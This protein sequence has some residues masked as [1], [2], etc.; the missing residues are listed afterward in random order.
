MNVPYITNALISNAVQAFIIM[1]L[2]VIFGLIELKI[3]DNI[4]NL[5]IAIL[6]L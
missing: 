3:E 4:V 5:I 6:M 1:V 2:V